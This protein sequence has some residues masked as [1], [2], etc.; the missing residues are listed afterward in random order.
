[1]TYALASLFGKSLDESAVWAFAAV[2]LGAVFGI[3]LLKGLASLIPIFGS[4]VK[5]SITF[6]LHQA[7][8]WGL[9]WLFEGGRDLPTTRGEFFEMRD[10]GKIIAEKEKA[11]TDALLASL[12]PEEREQIKV[13]QAKIGK[14]TSQADVDAVLAK[15]EGIYDGHKQAA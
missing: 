8:G 7:I 2:V 1:M 10:R 14:A 12:S 4:G 6:G 15:I 9:Y 3:S 11:N 13:L 5:A